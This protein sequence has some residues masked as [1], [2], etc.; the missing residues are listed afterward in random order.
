MQEVK[1][2][3][4]LLQKEGDVGTS[5]STS[6]FSPDARAAAR[7]SHIHVELVDLNRF[8]TLWQEFYEKLKEEDK[9][10][11]PLRPISFLAALNRAERLP[12]LLV[13]RNSWEV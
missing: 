6:G 11:L 2:L 4:G 8:I 3:I 7:G 9:S 1:Q 13:D 5:V 10:L 12:S